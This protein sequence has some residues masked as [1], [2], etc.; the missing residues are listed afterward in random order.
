MRA[1]LVRAAVI[2]AEFEVNIV[3]VT[4]TADVITENFPITLIREVSI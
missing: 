4:D 3:V 1:K 2:R